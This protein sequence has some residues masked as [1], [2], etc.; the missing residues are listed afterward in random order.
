MEI[1]RVFDLLPYYEEHFQPKDDVLAGKE[2]GAWRKYSIKE[3]R[4][5]VDNL[6]YAFLKLGVERNDNIA[7]V[8]NNRPEWNFIDMAVMQVG[9]VH[10]PIYPTISDSDYRH[11]LNHA[12]IKYLFLSGMAMYKRLENIIKEMDHLKGV[13]IFNDEQGLPRWTE[14]L[15]LGKANAD[16]EKLEAVKNSITT[17][18][19]CTLIYTSGTTGVQK[20]VLLAHRGLIINFKGVSPTPDFGDGS[21]ALSLLPLSHVYERMLNYMYLYLGIS[22]YYAESIAKFQ[23][24][25]MEIRPYMMCC[26][27]RVIEKVYEGILAKGRKLKG[28]KKGLFFWALKIAEKYELY[29]AN[30]CW[31]QFKWKI[32][33]TLVLKKFRDALGGRFRIVVSGGSALNPKLC[34]IFHA[35]LI[36]VYEGYGLTETSPVIT[37]SARP[38]KGLKIGTVGL[39]LPGVEVK[40]AE[41]GEVLSKG[42]NIMIG[43]YRAPELNKTVIDD[44][45]W[46]HTG[47][48]GSFDK[49]G[50]LIITGRM[51]ENFKT[52]G[53]KWIAPQPIENKLT[54]SP[55]I[56]CAVVM[57]ENQKLAGAL[58]VPDF[59]H[60]KSWC[61]IKEIPYTTNAEM[62]KN[63]LVIDRIKKVVDEVNLSLGKTEQIGRIALVADEWSVNSGE[64]S[65][66]LKV[67][68]KIVEEKYANVIKNMFN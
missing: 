6:S 61:K 10:V 32:A 64:L 17:N 21:C 9:A 18:D 58:I 19:P 15:E 46:F 38:P 62:V 23:A 31:Y 40:I 8:T 65:A 59:A 3:F 22:I 4:E 48:I 13:Y 54:A 24:N 30:G 56:D 28:I 12:Q 53:G 43:Y 57:G 49:D 55:F 66:T 63:Q 34:R 2:N 47:D 60:I 52:S 39:P 41:N 67:K 16:K 14:L 7:T 51:K 20:G 1:T 42:P 50:H 27:P 37:V 44:D 33:Y 45:G 11:I 35:A 5:I 25:C 29:G 26:V 36:P 68:R